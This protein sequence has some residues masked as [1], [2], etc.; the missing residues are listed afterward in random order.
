[1][2]R[3]DARAIT[4]PS[5]LQTRFAR[6]LGDGANA[7]VVEE[8]VSIEDG[9]RDALVDAGFADDLADDLGRGDVVVFLTRPFTSAASV[10]VVRRSRRSRRR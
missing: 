10:E 8:A 2:R 5:D 4:L 9:C 3:T 6:A 1:M 7:S